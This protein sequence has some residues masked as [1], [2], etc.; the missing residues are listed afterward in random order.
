[1]PSRYC[2]ADAFIEAVSVV[3]SRAFFV[4]ENHGEALVPFADLLN[5]H[6]QRLHDRLGPCPM[7]AIFSEDDEDACRA[8]HISFE[9]ENRDGSTCQDPENGDLLV[10]RVEREIAI[11]EE[12]MNCYGVISPVCL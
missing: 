11:G 6:S 4:D 1:M 5:S 8:L 9:S 3:A 12:I 7:D 10:I 2:N